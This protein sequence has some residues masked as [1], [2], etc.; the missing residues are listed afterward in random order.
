MLLIFSNNPAEDVEEIMT[1][2]VPDFGTRQFLM[3][4][5]WQEPGQLLSDSI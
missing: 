2:F 1:K 4:I 5:F 3:K